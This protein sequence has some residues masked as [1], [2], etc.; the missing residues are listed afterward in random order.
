MWALLSILA[1][2][3]AIATQISEEVCSE[4]SCGFDVSGQ[5]FDE[6]GRLQLLQRRGA[7]TQLALPGIWDECTKSMA[8]APGLKCFQQNVYYAQCLPECPP[9][10]HGWDCSQLD[11]T[12]Q[13]S[14][15]TIMETSATTTTTEELT[16]TTTTPTTTTTTTTA[17]TTVTTTTT[18]AITH[19]HNPYRYHNHNNDHS[20][21]NRTNHTRNNN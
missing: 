1:L 18:T 14:S 17:T 19:D 9:A 13:A 7:K 21:D 20:N 4:D 2:T 12:T 6:D 11:S 3:L 8:C 16:T 5:V 10:H 15:S